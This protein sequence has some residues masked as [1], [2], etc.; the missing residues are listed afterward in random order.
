MNEPAAARRYSAL[1]ALG[2]VVAVA[3]LVVAM[4]PTLVLDPGPAP[5]LFEATERHVRWGLGVAVGAMFVVNGWRRPWSVLAAWFV[6]CL[7]GGYLL[8][9]F[10]G[11]AIQ[12]PEDEMQWVLA[13]VELVVCGIAAVWI[14]HRREAPDRV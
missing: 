6:L 12:G 14:R 3:S 10:V 5:N 11:M 2:A 7:S 13:G 9:R 8:A 1:Q 4:A